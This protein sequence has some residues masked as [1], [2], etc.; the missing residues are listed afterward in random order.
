VDKTTKDLRWYF[1]K[2][3]VKL[4]SHYIGFGVLT[5]VVMKGSI[6][7]VIMLYSP[8]EVNQRAC[9]LRHAGFLFG[10]LFNPED[11]GEMFL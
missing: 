1:K 3:T 7:W 2:K 10:L 5:A 4:S 6:F 11:G 8:L 9:Y